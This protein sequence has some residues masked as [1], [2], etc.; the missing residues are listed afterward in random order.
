MQAKEDRRHKSNIQPFPLLKPPTHSLSTSQ[1]PVNRIHVFLLTKIGNQFPALVVSLMISPSENRCS[2]SRARIVQIKHFAWISYA[3][4]YN[5]A[6]AL[7]LHEP[8]LIKIVWCAWVAMDRGKCVG[9]RVCIWL[10]I[11]FVFK[12]QGGSL[13]KW[14]G[15]RK[16]NNCRL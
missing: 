5:V 13:R 16:K 10:Q 9:G 11:W 2:I 4:K 7:W 3:R 8:A 12:D 14:C 1:R 6:I 15:Y